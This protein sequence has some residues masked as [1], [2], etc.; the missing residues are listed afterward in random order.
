MY[1]LIFFTQ[2]DFYKITQLLFLIL[3]SS[4]I[5]NACSSASYRQQIVSD[6]LTGNIAMHRNYH[7]TAA[8]KFEKVTRKNYDPRLLIQCVDAAIKIGDYQISQKCL[9]RLR[10]ETNRQIINPNKNIL[11]QLS[12]KS[13]FQ[14]QINSNKIDLLDI[15]EAQTIAACYP[16][17]YPNAFIN[18]IKRFDTNKRNSAIIQSSRLLTKLNRYKRG[19]GLFSALVEQ[20]K[21][22]KNINGEIFLADYLRSTWKDKESLEW[23]KKGFDKKP[24]PISLFVYV[25]AL[26]INGKLYEAFE[27]LEQYQNKSTFADIALSTH[28]NKK[29]SLDNENQLRKFLTNIENSSLL[30]KQISPQT[31]LNYGKSLV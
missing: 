30:K 2:M 22:N 31:I 5:T 15:L 27:L 6:L 20:P 14:K 10:E 26:H 21:I 29:A 17:D 9:K 23:A 3:T 13:K 24:N 25:E 18:F 19:V 1:L 12:S 28:I 7:E 8:E 16:G 11:E 4:L